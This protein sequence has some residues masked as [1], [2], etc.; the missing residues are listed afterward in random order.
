MAEVELVYDR[1][2]PNVPEARAQLRRAFASAELGGVWREW[3]TD[4]DAAPAH[5]RGYG[6]PTILVDGRD[7]AADEPAAG[8]CC[9]LYTQADGSM[10]GVPAVDAILAALDRANRTA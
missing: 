1:D 5:V 4:D 2:C 8:T 7:V 6:S 3:C 10:R 9:R